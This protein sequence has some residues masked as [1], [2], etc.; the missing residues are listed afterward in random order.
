[1]QGFQQNLKRVKVELQGLNNAEFKG[2][3]IKVR[4]LR[5]HLQQLLETM[6]DPIAVSPDRLADKELKIQL[7]KQSMIKESAIQ[8]KTRVHWLKVCNGNTF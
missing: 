4:E 1:M 8:Q 6:R 3:S 7:E 2:V 5:T